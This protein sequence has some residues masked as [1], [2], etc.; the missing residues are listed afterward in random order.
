MRK[1]LFFM[2]ILDDC[3]IDWLISNGVKQRV[4]EGKS[5]IIE[6]KE[7]DSMYLVLEGAFEV[8]TSS[9]HVLA[10]LLSG[11]LLGEISFVDSMPPTATVLASEPSVVMSIS[12]DQLRDK[13]RD[14]FHFAS[15]FYRAL[16]N[17]L[18]DRLRS[19]IAKLGGA[20]HQGDDG[21]AGDELNLDF[22]D[23]VGLAGT[24]FDYLRDR[25]RER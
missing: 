15:R 17:F 25:L 4:P 14:D 12:R 11:E 10:R 5:L 2:A 20:K 13:L 23:N 9:G 22:L 24:R 3:D 1:A 21:D 19:T 16:A 8:Q 18:A 6:G 7:I